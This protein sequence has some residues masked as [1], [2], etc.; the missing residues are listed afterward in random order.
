MLSEN[1][2]Q[3]ESIVLNLTLVVLFGLM[4]FAVHDVLKRNSVPAIGRFVAYLVLFLG[5]AGFLA[6]GIIQIFWH[7]Q[8][9]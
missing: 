9:L 3:I 1:F 4:F 6:K 2:E 5:A 8:G 7:S